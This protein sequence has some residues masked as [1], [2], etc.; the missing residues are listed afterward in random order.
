MKVK[1]WMQLSIQDLNIIIDAKAENVA[2]GT[3]QYSNDQTFHVH[4]T[5]VQMLK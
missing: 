5:I 2:D 3:K 1:P 4:S